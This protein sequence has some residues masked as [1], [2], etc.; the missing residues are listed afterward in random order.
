[1]DKLTEVPLYI[2]MIQMSGKLASNSIHN[3]YDKIDAIYE[4][5]FK[6]EEFNSF[7]DEIN[8][9]QKPIVLSTKSATLVYK[10][11]NKNK[12]ENENV[13]TDPEDNDDSDNDDSDS[14]DS[15]SDNKIITLDNNYNLVASGGGKYNIAEHLFI[16]CYIYT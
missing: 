2:I 11:D 6:K 4:E 16:I 8:I 7:K 9:L 10:N 15:D 5:E 3:F 14:D 1:M 12:N 13:I